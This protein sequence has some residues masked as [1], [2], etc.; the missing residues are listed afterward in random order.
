MIGIPF[1]SS[2]LA[3]ALRLLKTDEYKTKI[4]PAFNETLTVHL[5]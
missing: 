4:F 3:S 1:M 2:S 5:E